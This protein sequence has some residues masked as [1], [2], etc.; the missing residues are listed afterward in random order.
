M[1]EALNPSTFC[2]VLIFVASMRVEYDIK[3]EEEVQTPD[4][5]ELE[6]ETFIPPDCVVDSADIEVP[7]DEGV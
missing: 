2:W 1:N 7:I 4:T 3:D 6:L 5:A